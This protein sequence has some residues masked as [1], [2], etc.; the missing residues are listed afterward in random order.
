[1][2]QDEPKKTE[3]AVMLMLFQEY[4][5]LVLWRKLKWE[6]EG[7]PLIA[8][9]GGIEKDEAPPDAVYREAHQ[10]AEILKSDYAMHPRLL[11]II[12]TKWT[13][14]MFIYEARLYKNRIVRPDPTKFSGYLWL[15]C[16]QD[17]ITQPLLPL[18]MPALQ[19]CINK[20]YHKE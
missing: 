14:K 2:T 11:D 13:K 5:F 16:K 8:I 1:M 4:R 10:E 19:H 9:A 12:S 17:N 6:S 20:G 3:A 7:T 18:M 15:P